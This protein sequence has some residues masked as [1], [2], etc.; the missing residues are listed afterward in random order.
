MTNNLAK[1]KKTIEHLFF[2]LVGDFYSNLITPRGVI[3]EIRSN[4]E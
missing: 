1:Y 4:L 2:I 3:F